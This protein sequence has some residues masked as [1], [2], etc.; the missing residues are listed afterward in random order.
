MVG[1]EYTNS[2]SSPLFFNLRLNRGPADFNVGHNLNVSY[3]W[4]LG[5]PKWKTEFGVWALGGWQLGGVFQASTGVPFTPGF[6]GDSLGVGSTEPNIDVPNVVNDPGCD[7]YVNPGN[8][9]S[10]VRTECI[11]APYR[12]TLRSHLRWY[13]LTATGLL[14]IHLSA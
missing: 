7:S 10:Y 11:E 13:R 8:P 5:I 4:V 14:I 6:A 1:D 12:I 2:I 9:N 3:T